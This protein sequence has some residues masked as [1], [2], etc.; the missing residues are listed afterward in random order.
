VNKC[1]RE[2]RRDP[3]IVVFGEDVA[4]SREDALE[5]VPGKGGVFS[6]TQGL[7]REFGGRRVFNAPL[8]EANIVGRAIGVATRGLK[9][10]AEIQF[11]DY[12]WPAMMQIRDELAMMRWRSNGHWT[13]P[14]VLR[15]PIGGYL[16]GGAV[17]RS[18]CGEVIFTHSPGL[19]RDAIERRRRQGL[20]AHRRARCDG[21]VFAF[22]H[23]KPVPPAV[24]QSEDPGPDY[25]VPFGKAA[26]ARAGTDLTVVTYGALVRRATM[27]AEKLA[28]VDGIR[29]SDRSEEL[30][31]LGSRRGRRL[32]AA[33]ESLARRLRGQPELWLWRRGRGLGGGGLFEWLDAPVQRCRGFGRRSL[34]AGARGHDPARSK[35]TSKRRCAACSPTERPFLSAKLAG[36]R[37]ACSRSGVRCCKP[38]PL[39]YGPSSLPTKTLSP[40]GA[41]TTARHAG[42]LSPYRDARY[43]IEFP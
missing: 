23:F 13:A 39:R 38:T 37:N 14:A 30:V 3:R 28:E 32:G 19:C 17:Y 43:G 15:V 29:R 22:L 11:F 41:A 9:P 42:C 34:F 16:T 35:P 36:P 1:L 18:Q 6:V 24:R 5:A 12:I 40:R 31:A 8:A 7:Q 25:C 33:D 26:T 4:D 21:P 20:V 27:A 2:V 10:V